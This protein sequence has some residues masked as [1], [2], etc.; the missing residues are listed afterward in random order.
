[1]RPIEAHVARV[2]EWLAKHH[3]TPYPVALKWVRRIPA[4]HR[5][6]KSRDRERGDY[7]A[8]YTLSDAGKLRLEIHLSRRMLRTLIHEWA[9]AAS[10]RHW[11]L[12]VRRPPG[13]HDEEWGLAYARI[14]RA[15][16][17]EGGWM[18]AL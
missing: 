5:R 12:E 16:Y 6:V 10:H 11:K 7:A 18:E 8:T 1:M 3:P 9:H 17:D 14:Y 4:E 13:L 15:F 2:A